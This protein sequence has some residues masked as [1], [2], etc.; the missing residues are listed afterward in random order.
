MG[1]GNSPFWYEY[2]QSGRRSVVIGNTTYLVQQ[3]LQRGGHPLE[4]APLQRASAEHRVRG[5]LCDFRPQR[6]LRFK[7][8]AA[9]LDEQT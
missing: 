6:L 5:L 1:R 9:E 2:G 3:M 7:R 8:R 4:L